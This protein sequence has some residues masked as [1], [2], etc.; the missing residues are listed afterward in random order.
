MALQSLQCYVCVHYSHR[1]PLSLTSVLELR[2]QS[3]NK[4]KQLAF[5]TCIGLLFIFF[6]IHGTSPLR[7]CFFLWN[8]SLLPLWSRKMLKYLAYFPV[9]SLKIA[10]KRCVLQTLSISSRL[11]L[12]WLVGKYI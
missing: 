3:L 2:Y 12:A 9:E 11:S 4:K 5:S 10:T 6:S 8:F 7:D 1:I